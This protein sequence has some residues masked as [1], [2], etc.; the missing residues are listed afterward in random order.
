MA[1]PLL[2]P[3]RMESV[4]PKK[5]APRPKKAR[6]LLAIAGGAVL[7]A[8]LAV[9]AAGCGDESTP[10]DFPGNPFPFD[11]LRIDLSHEDMKPSTD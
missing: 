1:R 2:K 4:K 3:L 7:A 9:S 6:A 10:P 8:T 5:R 11:M